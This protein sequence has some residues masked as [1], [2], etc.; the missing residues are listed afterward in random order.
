MQPLT[1]EVGKRRVLAPRLTGLEDS[2]RYWS[3]FMVVEH[4]VIVD[5]NMLGILADLV[6]GRR[7]PAPARIEDFKPPPTADRGSLL[8]FQRLVAEFRNRVSTWPAR[9]PR[10]AMRI[11]GLVR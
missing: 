6:A 7:H 1:D 2:S 10:C 3:P 5:D 4:L 11:R 9:L 8:S